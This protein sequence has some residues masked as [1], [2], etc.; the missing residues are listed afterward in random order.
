LVGHYVNHRKQSSPSLKDLLPE[1][2]FRLYAVCV[3]FPLNLS[4]QMV[5]TNLQAGVYEVPALHRRI[6]IIV[7]QEL[8]QQEQ[9][10]LLQLFSTWVEQ[11]QYAREHYKPRT[12]ELTTLFYDLI[13]V[14]FEDPDMPNV[15]KDY[16]REKI[17]ELVKVLPVEERLEGIPPKLRMEGIPLEKRLVGQSAE[18]LVKALSPEELRA[19]VEAGQ[20]RLQG[21]GP[22]TKSE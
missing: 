1:E 19:V 21:N 3:R 11:L 10:A 13:K 7:V 20:R 12:Q 6:R 4:P 2:D 8:P 18:E 17:K 9:N 14:Y 22:S 5:L 16:A 15:I